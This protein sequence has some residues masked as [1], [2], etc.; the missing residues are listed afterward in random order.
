MIFFKLWLQW[1]V[2][3]N[4]WLLGG[5]LFLN[6]Q[7]FHLFY[8]PFS[9]LSGQRRI[10]Q[11]DRLPKDSSI[12]SGQGID[13]R[14]LCQHHNY[15][16]YDHFNALFHIAFLSVMYPDHTFFVAFETAEKQV[17]CLVSMTIDKSRPIDDNLIINFSIVF[18]THYCVS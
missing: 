9:E 16:R 12:P 4:V 18:T 13:G 7:I 14:G 8:G 6:F 5:E 1:S 2:G 11:L 17:H 10:R 3:Q 15:T